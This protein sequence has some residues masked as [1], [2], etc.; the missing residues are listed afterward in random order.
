MAGKDYYAILDVSKKA[1]AK[2]IKQAYRKMARKHH[3]DVNP[4]DKSA[5]AKFKEI[6]QAHEVLSDPEK[7][8]KYD[9][10]G[11]NWQYAD[12]FTQ[13]GRQQPAR[14]FSKG[15]AR[16]TFHFEDPGEEGFGDIFDSILG[17]F[18][19]RR[20]RRP[21][22][23]RDYEYPVE[24][25]LEEAYHGATR[26]LETQIEETCSSCKGEGCPSCG[27]VGRI[28]RPKRLEVKIPPGV[29]NGS[30]VR[31]AGNG[32]PGYGGGK[33]G[34]I[35]LLISV[36]ADKR[37]Q[38]TGDD[39]HVEVP[40]SLLDAVLGSEVQIP[41]IGGKKLALKIPAETQNG[42]AFRLSGQ[43]MPKLGSNSKG[44]LLAKVQVVLPNRLSER[45]KELFQELKAIRA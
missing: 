12:Q 30:K 3:P 8:K 44:D 11:D 36:K 19:G 24:V 26:M 28:I 27:G 9:Q 18:G 35:Y 38:R 2:E 6:N 15:G 25:S 39:L 41:T 45:E 20:A 37:F 1:T 43:G 33:A 13:A 7:R 4:G 21:Q 23:G 10:Y 16:T 17:G 42:K 5:E 29:K 32:G 40:V 31:I 14:N 34:D 22:R